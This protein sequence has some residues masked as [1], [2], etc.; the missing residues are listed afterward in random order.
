MTPKSLPSDVT[1]DVGVFNVDTGV[2]NVV[3]LLIFMW[4]DKVDIG[5]LLS[6]SV[7]TE[8][9][10]TISACH[11]M[12]VRSVSATRSV[13]AVE[14]GTILS[15]G[16][17]DGELVSAIMGGT[18]VELSIT[19]SVVKGLTFDAVTSSGDVLGDSLLLL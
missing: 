8:S 6:V 4:S 11:V 19:M 1:L 7:V 15:V 17:G 9:L 5:I 14:S 16:N 3:E 18:V 10:A 12:V 13:C 2:F